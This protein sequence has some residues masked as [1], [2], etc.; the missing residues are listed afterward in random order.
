MISP[1]PDPP[2]RSRGT[3]ASNSQFVPRKNHFGTVPAWRS[4]GDEPCTFLTNQSFMNDGLQRFDSSCSVFSLEVSDTSSRSNS[5]YIHMHQ[6]C[7]S[8]ERMAGWFLWRTVRPA[9][10]EDR[11]EKHRERHRDVLM[12]KHRQGEKPRESKR[13]YELERQTRRDGTRRNE[14]KGESKSVCEYVSTIA[15]EKDSEGVCVSM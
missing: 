6:S 4:T 5:S 13:E 1:S 3:T 2:T 11:R 9:S 8:G 12:H 14:S 15:R 10:R 7:C